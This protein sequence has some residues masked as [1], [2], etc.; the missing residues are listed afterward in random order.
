MDRKGQGKESLNAET[1]QT[2]LLLFGRKKVLA[3]QLP[4]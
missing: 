3:A 4:V 2:T 1:T